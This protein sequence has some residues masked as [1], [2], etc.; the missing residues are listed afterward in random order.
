MSPTPNYGWRK[1]SNCIFDSDR[2]FEICRIRH[3]R[4]R[5][6]EI[7]LYIPFVLSLCTKMSKF[8]DSLRFISYF[9]RL[10]LVRF[11]FKMDHTSKVFINY[12]QKTSVPLNSNTTSKHKYVYVFPNYF[13]QFC[14][15]L[16]LSM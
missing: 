8:E 9:F 13:F 3:I 15:N 2:R 6:I 4:V 11:S 14:L 16:K 12:T 1:Q 7:R 5:D 10:Y